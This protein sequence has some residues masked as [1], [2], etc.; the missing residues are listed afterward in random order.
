L[1]KEIRLLLLGYEHS[2]LLQSKN[3][4]KGKTL[5]E[6]LLEHSEP[7]YAEHSEI[8]LLQVKQTIQKF[9]LPSKT[10]T[11]RWNASPWPRAHLHLVAEE[12]ADARRRGSRGEEC[13]RSW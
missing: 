8:Q 6:E 3:N 4:A 12:E 1:K 5:G 9:T 11:E 7:H 10:K 2:M 13:S